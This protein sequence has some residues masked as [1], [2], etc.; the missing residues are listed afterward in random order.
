MTHSASSLSEDERAF[1]RAKARARGTFRNPLYQRHNQRR[2]EHLASLGL[3]LHG[4]R[5]LEV[6]AGVGDHVLF[7]LDRGCTMVSVEPRP[8]NYAVFCE[9]L[10]WLIDAGYTN[11]A[12]CTP[13]KSDIES[14]DG[15]VSGSFDIVYSYGLLYHVADPAAA[16]E[17]MAA[18]CSGVLLLETVV[19]FGTDDAL[20]RLAEPQLVPIQSFHG[21]GCRPTRLWVFN[22][23][24]ALFPHVYV[25]ATQPADP[26]TFPL[27]W[28]GEPPGDM[29]RAIFVA[30]RSAISNPLL[31]DHLPERQRAC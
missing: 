14:L 27:D 4:K 25:P 9:A 11:A 12:R 20:N 19:S 28:T 8:E 16:L 1:E 7:F 18:H 29:T 13:I 10:R 2:Q 6:G 3:D 22:R 31:L 15:A 17:S 21:T 23:L 24:K 26:K 5:V 30:S